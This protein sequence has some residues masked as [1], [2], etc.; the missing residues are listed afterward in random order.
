ML[1][2]QLC[3]YRSSEIFNLRDM[4]RPMEMYPVYQTVYQVYQVYQTV[5]LLYT[6]WSWPAVHQYTPGTNRYGTRLQYSSHCFPYLF[7]QRCS[8]LSA[9]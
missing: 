5:S 4:C 9:R 1:N 6:L 7:R 8:S 3:L 2:R